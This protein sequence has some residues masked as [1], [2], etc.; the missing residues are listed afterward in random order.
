MARVYFDKKG[1]PQGLPTGQTEAK[2]YQT[3]LYVDYDNLCNECKGHIYYTYNKACVKCAQVRAC[4]LYSYLNGLME[5][6]GN[7][8]FY[9]E[10]NGLFGV[11]NRT[12]SFD[13]QQELDDLALLMYIVPPVSIED[14]INKGE[15]LWLTGDPCK[16]A[17]HY[18]IKT[19]DNKCYFCEEERN[20]SKPRVEARKKRENWYIPTE[21]CDQ[22]GQKA[23]RNVQDNRCRGCFVVKLSPRQEAI[24]AGKKWYT[25]TK[26]CRICNTLAERYV[27]NGTCKGCK[28]IPVVS[29]TPESI[30][31]KAQPDLIITKTDAISFGL[32]V[33]RT[34]KPCKR[35]HTGYRYVSTNNCIDCLKR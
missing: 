27:D 5:F 21:P 11:A 15:T 35:G 18:G 28:P 13:F 12:V 31:M 26:P 32:K 34:G 8:T 30:M 9:Y 17:G 33:F 4:D 20:K 22:C 10:V 19:L 24:R 25:P 6:R 3:E 29:E 23:E 2:R 16:K 1:R 14:A 7:T